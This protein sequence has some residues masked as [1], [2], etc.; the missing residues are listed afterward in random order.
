[1]NSKPK[2]NK[3]ILQVENEVLNKEVT[4]QGLEVGLAGQEF[5]KRR[6]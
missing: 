2:N 3:P 4:H 6:M 5:L 1:M